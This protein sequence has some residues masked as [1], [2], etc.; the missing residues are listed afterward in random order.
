MQ[1]CKQLNRDFDAYDDCCMFSLDEAEISASEAKQFAKEAKHQIDELQKALRAEQQER[2]TIEAKLVDEHQLRISMET[3]LQSEQSK[4]AQA[5]LQ[6]VQPQQKVSQ[7]AVVMGT[8]SPASSGHWSPDGAASPL[9]DLESPPLPSVTIDSAM[10]QVRQATLRAQQLEEA[11]VAEKDERLRFEKALEQT[12]EQ[13]HWQE[14]GA[15]PEVTIAWQS[16]QIIMMFKKKRYCLGSKN[17]TQ[18]KIC[19]S[20]LTNILITGDIPELAHL[21]NIHGLSL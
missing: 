13:L 18:I 21:A 15:Q 2:L 9:R 17:V 4:A 7:T 10:E 8:E 19:L 3:N 6:P 5:R 20:I 12:Q 16:K 1:F 11:L 14:Y